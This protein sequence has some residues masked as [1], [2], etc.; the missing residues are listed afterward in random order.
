[1]NFLVTINKWFDAQNDQIKTGVWVL[2][3]LIIIFLY[4]INLWWVAL[5]F[6]AGLVVDKVWWEWFGNKPTITVTPPV[7]ANTS[8]SK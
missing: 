8:N 7:V 1:M 5:I 6:A 2:T 4:I 3:T